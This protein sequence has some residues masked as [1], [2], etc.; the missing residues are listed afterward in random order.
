MPKIKPTANEEKCR[1]VRAC[2]VGNQK[3]YAVS[4]EQAAIKARFTE[5][6]FRNR[7]KHPEKFT[8]EEL[9]ALGYILKFDNQEKTEML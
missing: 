5:R 6:T 7:L 3:K 8:L 4:N 2:I 1:N 9:W